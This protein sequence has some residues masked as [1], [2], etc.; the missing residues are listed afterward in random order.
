M[1]SEIG[2]AALNDASLYFELAGSGPT[3]VLIH[4]FG[5]DA[6]V[7]DDQ[8]QY[9]AEQFQVLRYDLR[10]FG[11]SHS[12]APKP[13]S[14]C[15][16]LAALLAFLGIQSA[17][18]LGSSMGAKIAI[19]FALDCAGVTQSLMLAASTLIGHE[20]STQWQNLWSEIKAQA[21][22]QGASAARL[23]WL[24]HPLFAATLASAGA[25]PRLQVMVDNYSGSHW[26]HKDLHQ[27]T[28]DTI[29]RLHLIKAPT[30]IIKGALDLPDFQ[31]SADILNAHIPN[32]RSLT[33][34][35]C[36]HLP[37]LEEPELFNA[38]IMDFLAAI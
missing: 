8:F 18:L 10:G 17:H 29:Q 1:H 16:D 2:N 31:L 13:Y 24:V 5:L 23:R 28:T 27:T 34:P 7:W 38:L 19:N 21:K 9:F 36:G 12:L 6:R 4:G 14:H 25:R 3:L 33:M 26:L 20:W 32:A 22:N 30:L 15:A 11:R 35:Q 37:N